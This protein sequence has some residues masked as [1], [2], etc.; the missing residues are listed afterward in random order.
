MYVHCIALA[1]STLFSRSRLG[2]STYL[3]EYSIRYLILLVY[4]VLHNYIL[5]K[6]SRISPCIC[7]KNDFGSKT[8]R[9]GVPL[10]G[11]TSNRDRMWHSPAFTCISPNRIPVNGTNRTVV[12]IFKMEV[13]LPFH[14]SHCPLVLLQLLLDTLL[15]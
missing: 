10:H 11:A 1:N 13:Y 3:S 6:D 9:T 2:L 14:R 5:L 8:V 7:S 15:L 4:I 12:R